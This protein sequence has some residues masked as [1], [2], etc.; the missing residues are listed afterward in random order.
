VEQLRILSG[1]RANSYRDRWTRMKWD[2]WL[3]KSKVRRKTPPV[4]GATDGPPENSKDKAW[5]T[6]LDVAFYQGPSPSGLG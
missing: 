1:E 4:A 5:A 3:S 2:R 6:R